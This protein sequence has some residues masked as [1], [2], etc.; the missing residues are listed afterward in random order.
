MRSDGSH[1]TVSI[2]ADSWNVNVLGPTSA[3]IPWTTTGNPSD[4]S[5]L[6]DANSEYG[7]TGSWAMSLV[8]PN[9][10]LYTQVGDLP[11]NPARAAGTHHIIDLQGLEPGTTY[12]FSIVSWSWR[13]SGN[14]PQP[15]T[16]T[17]I[18]WS[19]ADPRGKA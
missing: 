16:K 7:S 13:T 12:H 3:Q 19:N 8:R 2:A 15:Y 1:S 4:S 18:N 14:N 6:F 17:P 9:G 11:E 5:V 10:A